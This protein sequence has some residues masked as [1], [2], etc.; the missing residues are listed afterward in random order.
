MLGWGKTNIT[1]VQT[2]ILQEAEMP[3]LTYAQ[4]S[5]KNS[6]LNGNS[7]ITGNMMC[8]GYIADKKTSGCDGDSGGPFVCKNKKGKWVRVVNTVG[9]LFKQ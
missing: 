2:N 5:K 4:C 6:D 7:R 1:G 3:V 8:A 9:Y